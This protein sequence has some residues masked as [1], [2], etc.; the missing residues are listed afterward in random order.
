MALPSGTDVEYIG[1]NA[2]GGMSFGQSATEL[3]SF[4]GVTPA[5]QVAGAEQATITAT[6]VTISSGFGFSSSDQVISIIAQL[7]M[8]AHVLK[9]LGAWKGTA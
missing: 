4:Y 6:W 9:T 3:I 1:A 5:A 7:K 2:S 8:I